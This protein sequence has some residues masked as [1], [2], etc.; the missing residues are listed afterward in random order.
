M[1]MTKYH[2]DQISKLEKDLDRIDCE[3]KYH[4]EKL[5]VLVAYDALP[6]EDKAIVW[7]EKEHCTER[8]MIIAKLKELKADP[9]FIEAFEKHT[10]YRWYGVE[11]ANEINR[12]KALKES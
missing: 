4:R 7:A 9:V 10:M 8:D 12:V 5:V 2:L 11:V 1:D 6:P 3:I